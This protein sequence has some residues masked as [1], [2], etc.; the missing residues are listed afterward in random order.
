MPGHN[1]DNRLTYRRIFKQLEQFMLRRILIPVNFSNASACAVAVAR[2]LFPDKVTIRLL[3]VIAPSEIASAAANPTIN[4]MHA[5]DERSKATELLMEKLREWSRDSDEVAVEVGSAAE[6]ISAHA[7]EWGADLIVM[8]TRGRTGLSQFM[9]GSATEWLVRHAKQP[10][11]AV[12]DV[13]L[14]PNQA[15]HLPNAK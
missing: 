6:Q 1:R 5:K 14:N 11:L 12:H 15:K 10:V 9:H 3:S 8:G 2:D 13:E 7:D 4:P